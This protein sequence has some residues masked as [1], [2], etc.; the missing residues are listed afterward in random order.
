MQSFANTE[1]TNPW[2]DQCDSLLFHVSG[3]FGVM[4]M[5]MTITLTYG[6]M[7]NTNRIES[8]KDEEMFRSGMKVRQRPTRTFRQAM[9]FIFGTE[10][11]GPKCLLPL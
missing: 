9:M 6:V 7:T 4:A 1:N 5:A 10:S 2:L 8:T 11:L 3:L